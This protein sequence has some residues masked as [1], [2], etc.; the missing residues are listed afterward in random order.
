[1]L[2][3]KQAY[4]LIL[5]SNNIAIFT[6]ANPDCDGVASSVALK[7]HLES[8]GKKVQLFCDD[9]IPNYLKFIPFTDSYKTNCS[10]I[11]IYDLAIILDSVNMNRLGRMSEL[12]TQVKNKLVIDHHEEF[13]PFGLINVSNPKAAATGEMLYNFFIENNLTITKDIASCLY[14]AIA[15]DTGGFIQ[16]NVNNNTMLI[17]NELINLKID[18]L[19]INEELFYKKSKSQ[20]L[21]LKEFLNNTKFDFESRFAYCVLTKEIFDKCFAKLEDT[22][23]FTN[24]IRTIDDVDIS[25]LISEKEKNVFLLSIRSRGDFSACRIAKHFGGGGHFNAAGCRICGKQEKI[26]PQVIAAVKKELYNEWD[27]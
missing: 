5:K 9:Y 16:L 2:L 25:I 23:G 22:E 14:A 7:L 18:Y 17:V 4:S 1:M 11:E 20:F 26:L 24:H 3:N 13:I 6:H 27:Y 10:D 12:A 19:K 8:L 15:S 21:L